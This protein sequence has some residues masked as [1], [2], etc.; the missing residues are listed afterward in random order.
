MGKEI[1]R[2]AAV[3]VVDMSKRELDALRAQ[4]ANLDHKVTRLQS[5]VDAF[6]Q[7]RAEVAGLGRE[8]KKMT[9]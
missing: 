6:R 9:A 4:C 8:V 7:L 1:K 3:A 5:E 2:D